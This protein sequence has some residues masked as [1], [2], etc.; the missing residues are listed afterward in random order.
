MNFNTKIIREGYDG[1]KCLVHAR[2]CF[3]HHIA[4]AT[5]Q[6]LDVAGCDLFDGLKASFSFDGGASW[7]EFA[8]QQGLMPIVTE[9]DTIVGC[10]AT[11]MHHKKTGKILLLGQTVTYTAG[12]SRPDSYKRWTFYSIFDYETNTFSKMKLVEMP[13]GFEDCGNGSGQSLE[14]EN[15]D[16]LIPVYFT[17]PEDK[18]VFSSAVMRCNFDGENVSFVEMGNALTVNVGRGL[19]EPSIAY[20][21]GKYYMT[22]RNDECGLVAKS[23]DGINYSGLKLWCWQDGSILQ[24]YNTQQH[25]M[26]IGEDLYLVYTRRG[27]DN[28][29][30]FRHR[31]P[32]FAAK[33]E[34]MH[35]I[36]ETEF[37]LTPE[38]GA[39]CGNFGVT[40]YPDG[41]AAV[42]V[43]EWMQPIGCEK[44]GS[45]NA[46]F[47]SI[48][49]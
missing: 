44:H 32:L 22:L 18:G 38:R 24:N 25:F 47:L 19:Y 2:C 4:V 36:K 14:L 8:D 26:S 27:A 20:H 13:E 23:D 46:I 17:K 48:V 7:S 29:R 1:K 9:T 40:E 31:A 45:N 35:L 39:R 28:N 43:A 11:P 37:A 33:V 16:L 34:N 6:H 21:N 10:D 41:K 42:M 3:A 49:G 12:D 15:G 30:V 5:A